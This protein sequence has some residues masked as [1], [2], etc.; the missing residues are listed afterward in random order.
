[1]DSRLYE[2]RNTTA[3]D[4]TWDVFTLDAFIIGCKTISFE[5]IYSYKKNVCI[6]S[7]NFVLLLRI[8]FQIIISGLPDMDQY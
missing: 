7:H 4:I 3:R 2:G 8:E 6:N 1:M 5:F